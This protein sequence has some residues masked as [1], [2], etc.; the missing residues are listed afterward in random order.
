MPIPDLDFDLGETERAVRAT[1]HRFAE[2]IMRPVGEQLDKLSAGDVIA[3]DSMLWNV[4]KQYTDLNL[5]AVDP[6]MPPLAQARL[7]L[8]IAEEMGWG[9]SGFALMFGV[10]S[11]PTRLAA[12]SGRP[13]LME[14]F[15]PGEIGCWAITEPD[16]GSDMLDFDGTHMAVGGARGKPNIIARADGN[17]YV[18]SG[19]KSAWVSNGTIAK[20]AGLYCAVEMAD[21]R[22]GN[23]VFLVPLEGQSGVSRGKPLEKIGQRAGNQGEIFFDKLRIPA[24]YMVCDPEDYSAFTHTTLVGTNCWMGSVFGGVARAAFELALSYAK[25]RIQGGVPI[26]QHQNVKSRLFRMYRM[27][28]A[29]RSHNRRV[30]FFN[31]QSEVPSL[32]AAISSKVLSTQTAFEVASDALQIFGGAGISKEYPIEKIFRDARISMIEDGCNEV[33]G[34]IAADGLAAVDDIH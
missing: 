12:E 33:L 26:I 29:A 18:I 9:D 15:P 1:V 13:E 2:E 8:L 6:D 20:S 25:E 30:V 22:K 19:Q 21:G 27:T 7:Q 23:A 32:T 24:D 11:T 3:R 5:D 17:E 16:H 10:G 4:W 14:A 34:L 28:E 31:A